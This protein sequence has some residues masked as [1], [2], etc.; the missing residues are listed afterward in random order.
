MLFGTRDH[1]IFVDP[2][3]ASRP[4]QSWGDADEELA[5]KLGQPPGRRRRSRRLQASATCRPRTRIGEA[6]PGGADG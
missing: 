5:E 1:G 6:T 3:V 4:L 2:R